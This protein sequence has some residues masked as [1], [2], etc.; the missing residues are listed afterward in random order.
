MT[1]LQAGGPDLEAVTQRTFMFRFG[2]AEEFV[3]F[4]ARWYG[5]TVKALAAA[6]DSAALR[7]DLYEATARRR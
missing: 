2:S 6:Q 7:S 3:D 1:S 4:F 5:P